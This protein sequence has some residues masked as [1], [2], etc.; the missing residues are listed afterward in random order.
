MLTFVYIR[1]WTKVNANTIHKSYNSPT[2]HLISIR[3]LSSRDGW[4]GRTKTLH[5]CLLW[6]C[7]SC[8]I[9]FHAF[10]A[11]LS[12]S[13]TWLLLPSYITITYYHTYYHIYIYYCHHVSQGDYTHW[14]SWISATKSRYCLSR[15]P[16]WNDRFPRCILKK[17][18]CLIYSRMGLPWPSRSY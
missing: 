11:E 7:W 1:I 2:L 13:V 8:R 5:S 18:V 4:I 3:L 12:R 17:R 15:I 6:C 9:T 10:S 16:N 14:C